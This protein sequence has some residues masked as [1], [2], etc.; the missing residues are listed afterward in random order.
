M[1]KFLGL[2]VPVTLILFAT[3]AFAQNTDK[4]LIFHFSFDEGKGNTT[5]DVS[6]NKLEGTIINADWVEGV[7]GQALQ[8]NSG[9]LTVPAFG[10]D[11]LEELTIELW[12]KPTKRITY[13]DKIN[14]IY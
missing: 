8:F 7:V 6:P 5:E 3:I 10:V 4:D 12:F 9:A 13:G 1:R 2:L 14:M 11:E